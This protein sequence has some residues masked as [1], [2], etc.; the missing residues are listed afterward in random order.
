LQE[1]VL[2]GQIDLVTLLLEKGADPNTRT[3]QGSTPLH[4]AALKGH[5]EIVELLLG[6]GARLEASNGSGA[7]PLHD[8]ALGGHRAVVELLIER[9]APSTPATA[10]PGPHRCS[11][12]Q[13][14]THGCRRAARV[15]RR[16]RQC[17]QQG[18]RLALAIALKNGHEDLAA[19]LR[20]AVLKIA[21]PLPMY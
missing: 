21:L 14:G 20:D 13:V 17:P 5:K 11:S 16:G 9:G 3:A 6:R 7:T 12:P 15:Q 10:S 19:L 2:R 8:A 18:R 4:D 1:A